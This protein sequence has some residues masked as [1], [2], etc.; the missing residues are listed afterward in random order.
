[1]EVKLVEIKLRKGYGEEHSVCININEIQKM[2]NNGRLKNANVF[3][4]LFGLNDSLLFKENVNVVI[5][6]FSYDITYNDWILLY[7]FL[8][9]GKVTPLLKQKEQKKILK[10]VI[11]LL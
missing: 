1:M 9:S 4:H 2:Y 10:I 11:K 8:K 7:G 6:L 5:D 3:G